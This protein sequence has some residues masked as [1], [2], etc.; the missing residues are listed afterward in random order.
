ML[1]LND[2]SRHNLRAAIAAVALFSSQGLL[3]AS[4][5]AL[6]TSASTRIVSPEGPPRLTAVT[7]SAFGPTVAVDGEGR[8]LSVS[9]PTR[10]QL[11]GLTRAEAV[12]ARTV[13]TPDATGTARLALTLDRPIADSARAGAFVGVLPVTLAYN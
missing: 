1:N 11:Y 12:S 4:S 9:L 8:N 3:A 13:L 5:S 6:S 10:V 2:R 7:S